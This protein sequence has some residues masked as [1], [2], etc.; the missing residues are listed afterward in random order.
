MRVYLYTHDPMLTLARNEQETIELFG[1]DYFDE[2]AVEIP[3]VL[4][5]ELI[6][7][8][9]KL[10]SLSEQ[11]SKIKEENRIATSK[12]RCHCCGRWKTNVKEKVCG[13]CIKK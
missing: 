4:A 7:T 5:Q 11:A 2:Y 9:K 3:D 13:E 6:S 8:Y 10:C 1:D 12:G